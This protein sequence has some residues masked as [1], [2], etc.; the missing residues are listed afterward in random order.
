M[1]P[2]RHR[3]VQSGSERRQDSLEP[4][5]TR[6]IFDPSARRLRR[7]T[8]ASKGVQDQVASP[9]QELY[10]ELGE[11]NREAGRVGLGFLLRTAGEIVAIRVVV[12]QCQAVARDEYGL[13]PTI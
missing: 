7:R 5:R 2:V 10:E 4:A 12:A 6:S 13:G 11:L 9:G 1:T 3:P 8:T